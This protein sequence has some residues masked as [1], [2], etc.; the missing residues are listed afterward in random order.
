M[1]NDSGENIIMANEYSADHIPIEEWIDVIDYMVDE[2]RRLEGFDKDDALVTIETIAANWEHD[3]VEPTQ[4]VLSD[5]LLHAPQ[6]PI[7]EIFVKNY[8][9]PSEWEANTINTLELYDPSSFILDAG[10]AEDI[11]EYAMRT[12]NDLWDVLCRIHGAVAYHQTSQGEK[13]YNKTFQFAAINH[14]NDT[15]SIKIALVSDGHFH[16]LFDTSSAR[17]EFVQKQSFDVPKDAIDKIINITVEAQDYDENLTSDQVAMMITDRVKEKLS[18][19]LS[20]NTAGQLS[21]LNAPHTLY[22]T[23]EKS[24]K[25]DIGVESTVNWSR[26]VEHK[27]MYL[28]PPEDVVR[29]NVFNNKVSPLS[30]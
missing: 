18:L 9:S 29:N 16:I 27:S 12:G 23:L 13:T 4:E 26:G 6:V 30:Q 24:I 14:V 10:G 2:I 7:N 5:I 8:V 25:G 22:H 11:A 17:I 20:D 1:E 28:P 19:S 3:G 21:I 15:D